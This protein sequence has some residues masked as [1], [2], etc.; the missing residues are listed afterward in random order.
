V[1]EVAKGGNV[2]PMS[3]VVKATTLALPSPPASVTGTAIS[4]VEINVTW[5]AAQ[6]GMPL[7]SYRVNRGSSPSNL[8]QFIV[9]GP[10]T[11]SFTNYTVTSGTTYYYGIQSADTGGNISPMS[12]VVKIT[13]P[14]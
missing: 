7:A 5:T 12:A 13:T 4:K 3:A 6:S 9:L 2:S 14:N 1:E 8:T 11:T 10:T